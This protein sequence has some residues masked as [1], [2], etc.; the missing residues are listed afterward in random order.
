MTLSDSADQAKATQPGDIFTAMGAVWCLTEVR[1]MGRYP[2]AVRLKVKKDDV[3][4]Y[5]QC[6]SLFLRDL[7]LHHAEE[8]AGLWER[9]N[10]WR[11]K[12]GIKNVVTLMEERYPSLKESS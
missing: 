2:I 7:I 4:H 5:Q 6:L 1:Q 12:G 3:S 11:I 10:E 9:L 8:P